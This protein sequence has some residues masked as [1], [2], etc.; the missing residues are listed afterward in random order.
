MIWDD[1]NF[2]TKRHENDNDWTAMST[3]MF[4]SD[5]TKNKTTLVINKFPNKGNGLV[6]NSVARKK[7]SSRVII[8]KSVLAAPNKNGRRS[9]GL[10]AIH[11]NNF[12]DSSKWKFFGTKKKPIEVVIVCFYWSTLKNVID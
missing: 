5:E 3:K 12:F 4:L 7:R 6:K 8:R 2:S 1:S 11:K 10:H 9:S